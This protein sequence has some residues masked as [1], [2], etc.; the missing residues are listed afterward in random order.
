[1]RYPPDVLG[2]QLDAG[3][4][5]SVRPPGNV[6]GHQYVRQFV[7]WSC[8][9][10]GRAGFTRIAIPDIQRRTRNPTLRECVV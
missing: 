2:N 9:R 10:S 5:H 3:I 4:E 1:M 6:R 7:E 8:R